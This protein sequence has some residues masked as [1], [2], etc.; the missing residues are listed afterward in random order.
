MKSEL[1]K[2]THVG[3]VAPAYGQLKSTNKSQ[4]KLGINGLY[5][6]RNS[7]LISS[8]DRGVDTRNMEQN[9]NE[10]RWFLK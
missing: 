7:I 1:D 2:L 10:I 4:E 3:R 9:L 8:I 6:N 5:K